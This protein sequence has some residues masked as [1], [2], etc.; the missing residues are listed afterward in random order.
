MIFRS[1]HLQ[2]LEGEDLN[3]SIPSVFFCYIFYTEFF[4]GHSDLMSFLVVI[5]QSTSQKVLTDNTDPQR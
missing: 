1:P 4:I 5:T 2:I 3:S